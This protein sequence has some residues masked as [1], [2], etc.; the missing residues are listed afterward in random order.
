M[1]A[2]DRRGRLPNAGGLFV[3][4]RRRVYGGRYVPTLGDASMFGG[5]V[6]NDRET[7]AETL[8]E[9]RQVLADLIRATSRAR[10][11]SGTR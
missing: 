10:V 9:A 7:A 5:E 6:D 4:Y 2:G 3:S 11:Q 8:R 1:Y